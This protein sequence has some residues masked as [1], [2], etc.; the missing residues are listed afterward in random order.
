MTGPDP[1]A[2]G[3]WGDPPGDEGVELIDDDDVGAVDEEGEM[4]GRSVEHEPRTGPLAPDD[5]FSGDETTRD[6][7]TEDVPPAAEDAAVHI[8]D[9][10]PGGT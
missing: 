2:Y 4:V 5:E 10:I 1:M 6:Y 3:A 7:P 9:E 8:E